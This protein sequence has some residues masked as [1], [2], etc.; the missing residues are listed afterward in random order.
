MACTHEQ[1][2]F[3]PEG[4]DSQEIK[5]EPNKEDQHPFICN[6]FYIFFLPFVCR[7]RPVTKEDVYQVAK[8]DRTEENAMKVSAGW[9]KS[10][11]KYIKQIQHYISVKET[12]SKSTIKEPDKPSL[13]NTLI[14][15]LGDFKLVLAVVFML[16]ACGI[17]LAQPY[18]MEKM[19]E[20]VDERQEAEESGEKEPGFPFVSGLILI[21]CPFA[22]SIFTSLG[23]RYAIHFVARVRASLA[24][25]IFDSTIKSSIG[26]ETS[27]EKG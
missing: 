2:I 11:K 25:L 12:D 9:D 26:G 1:S 16:V 13:M 19:L 17:S 18:L 7:I 21:I 15:Q 4:L 10:V 23:M 22:N 8:D 6:L 20:I 14:F 3:L 24:C 5:R 27:E